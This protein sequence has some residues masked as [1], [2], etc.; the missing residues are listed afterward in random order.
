MEK[1]YISERK[2]RAI[3]RLKA[4]G[5]FARAGKKGGDNNKRRQLAKNPHYYEE[6]GIKGGNALVA[7]YGK[8]M[9]SK[10][11]SVKKGEKYAR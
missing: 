3:E 5:H 7:K 1:H 9:L 10:W 6:I 4:Q 11:G 8:E 2:R